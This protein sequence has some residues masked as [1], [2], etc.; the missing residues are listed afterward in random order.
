M[1]VEEGFK[2]IPGDGWNSLFWHP[3][4]RSLLVVYV[5]DFILAS[6]VQHRDAIWASLQK[7]LTLEEPDVPD[8]FLGCYM[9]QFDTNV[10][11]VMPILQNAPEL[12]PRH[13]PGQKK[14]DVKPKPPDSL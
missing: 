12:W 11:E 14:E 5:D 13:E 1:L 3:T 4:L 6:P 8:R 9:R 2:K 7:K 10:Q